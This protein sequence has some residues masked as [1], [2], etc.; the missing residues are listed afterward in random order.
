MIKCS[1]RAAG[2]IKQHAVPYISYSSITVIQ[3]STWKNSAS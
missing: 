2:R 1:Q 3:L